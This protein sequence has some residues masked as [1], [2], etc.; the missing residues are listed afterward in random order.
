MISL[1]Q[2]IIMHKIANNP[3]NMDGTWSGCGFLIIPDWEKAGDDLLSL[4]LYVRLQNHHLQ[5]FLRTLSTS[6]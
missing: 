1:S 6:L 2:L 3:A 5:R 4:G